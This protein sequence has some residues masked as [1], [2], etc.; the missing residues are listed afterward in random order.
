MYEERGT[1][2]CKTCPEFFDYAANRLHFNT[3]KLKKELNIPKESLVWS[4]EDEMDKFS[5]NLEQRARGQAV[6]MSYDVLKI[7]KSSLDHAVLEMI[8]DRPWYSGKDFG[9]FV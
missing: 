5:T 7:I 8:V 9:K 3:N 2:I 6:C 1:V 4:N